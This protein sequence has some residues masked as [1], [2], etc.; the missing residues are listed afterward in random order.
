MLP[1]NDTFLDCIPLLATHLLVF[2]AFGTTLLVCF[3]ASAPVERQTE[4][5]KPNFLKPERN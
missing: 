4:E 5:S 2:L 3:P 1:F